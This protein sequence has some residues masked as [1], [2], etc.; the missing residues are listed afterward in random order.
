MSKYRSV[1]GGK[2]LPDRHRRRFRS[3][4]AIIHLTIRRTAPRQADDDDHNRPANAIYTGSMCGGQDIEIV[5][6][7]S[8][9]SFLFAAAK[10]ELVLPWIS[11]GSRR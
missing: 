9:S 5:S 7:R 2:R 6:H 1:N 11:G 3:V 8:G 4:I 10:L